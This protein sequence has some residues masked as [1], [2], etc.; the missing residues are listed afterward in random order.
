MAKFQRLVTGALAAGL[1]VIFGYLT[2]QVVRTS[3]EPPRLADPAP[4]TAPSPDTHGRLPQQLRGSYDANARDLALLA[5]EA[6]LLTTVVA[7]YFGAKSGND[8]KQAAVASAAATT[9]RTKNSL[10]DAAKNGKTA[11]DALTDLHSQGLLA[12]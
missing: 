1:L 6:P 8:A 4:T 9:A 7:F 11:A 5:I 12:T 3:G 2:W 10:T